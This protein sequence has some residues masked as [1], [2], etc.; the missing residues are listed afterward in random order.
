MTEG[1]ASSWRDR[2]EAGTELALRVI[3]WVG[4]NMGRTVLRAI[5]VPIAFYF[6]L[7]RGIERKASRR[8]LEKATGETPS[9]SQ[10]FRHFLTFS[11]VTA[12]RLYLATGQTDKVSVHFHDL[13]QF[14]KLAEHG[15]GGI[16]LAAHFGSFEAARVLGMRDTGIHVRIV[17]NR[18]VSPK[19]LIKL[20]A[21]SSEFAESIIDPGQSAPSL[22]LNVA[23]ALRRGEWVGFLADR[24]LSE[25]RTVLCEFM[26]GQARFPLGPFL[27][28][29][30]FKAPVFCIF[31]IYINGRY[32]VFLEE[33]TRSMDIPRHG[34]DEALQ[35]YVQRFAKILETYVRKAPYN[36]FNFYDFWTEH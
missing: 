7:V 28:S 4:R 27:V 34:R 18:S 20:E 21:L 32:E 29:A 8:F 3:F 31:P 24:S 30:A 11:Q 2:P 23:E 33:I 6:F 17:L 35:E 15:S 9:A 19:L 25:D 16:I 13:A 10:V 26:G 5:L 1:R 36:W 14:Q 12:D 22:A